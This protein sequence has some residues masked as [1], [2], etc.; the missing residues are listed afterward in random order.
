MKCPQ[1]PGRGRAPKDCPACTALKGI[2]DHAEVARINARINQRTSLTEAVGHGP[3]SP[4]STKAV[5][6]IAKDL[7]EAGV[8]TASF[9]ASKT[10]SAPSKGKSTGKG[11]WV[12]IHPRPCTCGRAADIAIDGVATCVFCRRK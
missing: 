8:D 9:K 12:K 3:H 7:N 5:Q 1:H 2:S 10:I 6:K 4:R 11:E